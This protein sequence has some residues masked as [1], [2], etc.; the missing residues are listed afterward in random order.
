[1]DNSS[2]EKILS[3][4]NSPKEPAKL[5]IVAVAKRRESVANIMGASRR[6]FN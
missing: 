1:M 5:K 3:S 2:P 4:P 6:N